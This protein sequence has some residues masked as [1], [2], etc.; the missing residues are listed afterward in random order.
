M[1]Y[2][3][4][5]VGAGPGGLHAAKWANKRGLKVALIEKRKDISKITRYCSEHI[6]LD[7]DYNGDTIKVDTATGKISSVKNEWEIYYKGDFCPVTDKYYSSPKLYN[8]H[9]AW[10][11]KRPF[12]YK[13]GKGTLL[14]GLLEECLALGITYIPETTAYDVTDNPS[15]VELKCVSKGKKFKLQAKKLIAADGASAQIAQK[16]GRNNERA[17]LGFALCLAVYMSN[18]KEYSPSEWRGWWGRCYGTN[19]APLMG[20]GP[21]GHFDWA[22]MIILGSPKEPPLGTF[23]FFTKRGPLADRFVDAKVETMHC[24][25]TRAFT[26]IKS[27]AKGNNIMIGDAA[28][29]VEVQA[30]GALSCG[31]RAAEAVARELDGKPG[32]EE[33]NKWW[34]KSFEFNDEGMM[35]VTTGYAL[36]P[37]YTD[38]EIDY[39]FSLCD[40]H[41]MD[42]SWSQYKSPKMMWNLILKDPEKIKRERPEVWAKIQTRGTQTLTDSIKK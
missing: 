11:D 38:D 42:G 13:Y 15:G 36:I 39:L 21:E 35:Q 9:F 12:A 16:L 3:L 26:P 5:I 31:Y 40:G 4:A 17:Y 33:Y 19:L 2:D 18:V 6:I 7:E 27:P 29:F 8:C 30:Q 14:K 25:S 10:P 1:V 28:A 22:D 23:E 41:T 24:C 34:L 20:T 32:F 37:T